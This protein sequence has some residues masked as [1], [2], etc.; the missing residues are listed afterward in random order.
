MPSSTRPCWR[1]RVLR[2]ASVAG[3]ARGGARGT[4]R[5]WSRRHRRRPPRHGRPAVRRG[6]DLLDMSDSIACSTSTRSGVRSRSKPASVAGA[7]RLAAPDPG[8]AAAPWGIIQKQT[9]ADRLTLGGAL[10]SNAHGRGSPRPDR[11]GGRGVD[12]VDA[13]GELRPCS[14]EENAEL[15]RLAIGGYGLF[16]DRLGSPAARPAAQGRRVVT[17]RDIDEV[18]ATLEAR[19][20]DGRATAT[21]SSPSTPP[22]PISSGGHLSCYSRSPTRRRSR[23]STGALPR[24]LGGAVL[25]VARHPRRAFEAYT[26]HYL[27]TSGQIYWSD[28]H[29][30]A[31]Y[32]DDYHRPR[33]TLGAR[34][35]PRR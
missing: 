34:R 24:R 1:G 12:L 29:Q 4:R 15:F 20:D 11:G 27:A 31:A 19:A 16:G 5:G 2:P 14:R 7:D 23:T 25:P 33:S 3:R 9:G 8:R 6:L 10:S 18:V 17:S 28:L 35:P 26:R 22:A 21:F 30:L 13:D 32:L